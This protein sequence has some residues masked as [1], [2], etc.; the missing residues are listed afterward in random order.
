MKLE[1]SPMRTLI[2]VVCA[3]FSRLGASCAGEVAGQRCVQPPDASP[4]PTGHHRLSA[5][6]GHWQFFPAD[7]QAGRCAGCYAGGDKTVVVCLWHY[8]VPLHKSNG[9]GLF[10]SFCDY[11]CCC[12]CYFY[13][14]LSMAAIQCVTYS[15]KKKRKGEKNWKRRSDPIII[16]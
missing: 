5:H 13:S 15:R 4:C 14:I 12:F 10:Q 6:A 7:H 11:C 1:L 9:R 2:C 8:E 16:S 3:A